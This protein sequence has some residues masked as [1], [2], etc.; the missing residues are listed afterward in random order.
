[1]GSHEA[2]FLCLPHSLEIPLLLAIFGVIPCRVS[3]SHLSKRIG[4]F[5]SVLLGSPFCA[6]KNLHEEMLVKPASHTRPAGKRGQRRFHPEA[7]GECVL[8]SGEILR[9][10]RWLRVR[11]ANWPPRKCLW[12]HPSDQE[13]K[14]PRR[15]SS[16][17][18]KASH[19]GGAPGQTLRKPEANNAFEC[20]A[21]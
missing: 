21:G 4:C 14:P 6:S 19:R 16:S 1:M 3:S 9:K 2:S 17:R 12:R 13:A 15:L 7:G 10:Q 11:S 18:Q 5:D 8:R 20:S